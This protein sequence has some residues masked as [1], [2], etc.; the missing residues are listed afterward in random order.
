MAAAIVQQTPM[1]QTTAGE[2]IAGLDFTRHEHEAF[3]VWTWPDAEV[4]R[5]YGH[6]AEQAAA[7]WPDQN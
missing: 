4:A 5:I 7:G 1:G 6:A 3:Y 2:G